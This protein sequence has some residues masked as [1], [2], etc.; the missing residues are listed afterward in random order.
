MRVQCSLV[1]IKLNPIGDVCNALLATTVFYNK[2]ALLVKPTVAI[3]HEHWTQ[4]IQSILYD[5]VTLQ[6]RCVLKRASR[7]NAVEISHCLENV[8]SC[9]LPSLQTANPREVQRQGR[10]GARRHREAEQGWGRGT[11]RRDLRGGAFSS[12][13]YWPPCLCGIMYLGCLYRISWRSVLSGRTFSLVGMLTTDGECLEKA[14]SS[15][16]Q[17]SELPKEENGVGWVREER[18]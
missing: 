18:G 17:T 14:F 2:S 12:E 4:C 3:E 13:L 15:V 10:G 16:C 5:A 6:R 8:A 7:R 11:R 1:P 9:T